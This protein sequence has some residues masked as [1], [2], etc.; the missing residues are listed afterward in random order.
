L[1]AY[2]STVV[3]VGDPR[4]VTYLTHHEKRYKKYEYGKIKDFVL[5]ECR[6]LNIDIDEDKLC[7]S[8]RS[9][10]AICSI[11]DQLYPK[12]RTT[13]SYQEKK[14]G[15]DGVFVVSQAD[16]PSYLSHFKPVQL[17]YKVSQTVSPDY[18]VLNFGASKGATFDRV[19]IYPTKEIVSWIGNRQ[20]NLKDYTKAKFYVA[21]TRARYSVA[22]S[23]DLCGKPHE[24]MTEWHPE[25]VID[26]RGQSLTLSTVDRKR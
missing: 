1:I 7:G 22:I 19:L 12:F 8:Y 14:S 6:L 11:A 3:L 4:Q 16:T 17:R 24:G 21:L 20:T 10:A 13:I 9:N 26:S 5:Q 25:H 15:H 18:Q 23:C 2:D